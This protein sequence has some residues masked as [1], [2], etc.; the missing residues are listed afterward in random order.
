MDSNIRRNKQMIKEM[1]RAD[2]R[3]KEMLIECK[4]LEELFD[5]TVAKL[6]YEEQD[7]AWDFVMHCEQMSEYVLEMACTYMEFPRRVN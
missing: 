5:A 1:A 2:K 3:Y 7:I 6:S 4:L